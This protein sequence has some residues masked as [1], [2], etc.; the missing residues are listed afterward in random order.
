MACRGCATSDLQDVL[1][2][3]IGRLSALRAGGIAGALFLDEDDPDDIEALAALCLDVARTIDPIFHE[4]AY[5]GGLGSRSQA[6]AHA[7]YVSSAIAGN[8]DFELRERAELIA[9]R[10]PAPHP[11]DEHR[12]AAVELGVGLRE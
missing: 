11:D 4:I 12:L 2:T 6:S 9:T 1:G 10:R 3:A 7:A 8:L 5:R